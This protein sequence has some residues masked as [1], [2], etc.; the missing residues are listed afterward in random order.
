MSD[1]NKENGTWK[2]GVVFLKEIVPRFALTFVANTV[3][4]ENYETRPMAHSWTQEADRLEVEYSWK[5][6]DWHRFRISAAPVPVAIET[7][8]EHEFITEHYWGY[9]QLNATATSQYE[10]QHPRWMCYPV[11]DYSIEVDFGAV[12][13]EAFSFL[14]GLKPQSV[15]LAE[16]SEVSVKAGHRIRV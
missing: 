2:R 5:K 1:H 7:G 9:T 11:N 14:S 15:L 4:G 10:V 8:S 13:G 6:K 16:G 12:Y 3:Y